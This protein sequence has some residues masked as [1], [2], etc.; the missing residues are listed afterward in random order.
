MKSFDGKYVGFWIAI[1]AS[2]LTGIIFMVKAVDLV[3]ALKVAGSIASSVG[4]ED[5]GWMIDPAMG[6]LPYGILFAGAALSA[7]FIGHSIERELPIE[8]KVISAS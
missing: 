5:I 8:A 3:E 1:A 7:C 4:V 2:I 6:L